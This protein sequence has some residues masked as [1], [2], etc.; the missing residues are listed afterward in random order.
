MLQTDDFKEI[1]ELLFH[2]CQAKKNRLNSHVNFF[3]VRKDSKQLNPERYPE[4]FETLDYLLENC[5]KYEKEDRIKIMGHVIKYFGN[6]KNKKQILAETVK[7]CRIM[8]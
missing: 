6:L 2:Y 5:L 8:A 7:H 3:F 1:I 4:K